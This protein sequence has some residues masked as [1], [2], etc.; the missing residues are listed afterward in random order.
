MG[1]L[2]FNINGFYEFFS[3][4]LRN[5]KQSN[6]KIEYARAAENK[7]DNGKRAKKTWCKQH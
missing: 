1:S 3:V 6:K 5:G 2:L 4:E 7:N